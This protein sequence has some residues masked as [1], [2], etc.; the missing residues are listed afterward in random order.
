ML[1]GEFGN[2]I[3]TSTAA[4]AGKEQGAFEVTVG[5]TLIHSKLKLGHGKVQSDEEL[6]NILDYVS[7]ALEKRAAAKAS[8]GEAASSSSQS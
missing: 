7:G 1:H 8:D 6:D 3:A 5:G 4:Y 2:K